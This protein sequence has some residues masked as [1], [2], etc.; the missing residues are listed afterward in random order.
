MTVEH[1]VE[2]SNGGDVGELMTQVVKFCDVHNSVLR[3][4]LLQRGFREEDVQMEVKDRMV[5]GVVSLF[6]GE[7]FAQHDGCPVCVLEGTLERTTDEIAIQR[8]K[9]N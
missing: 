6:G 2:R 8:R 7:A 4:M 3:A 9:T 1:L 5:V